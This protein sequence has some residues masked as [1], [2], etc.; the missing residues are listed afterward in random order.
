MGTGNKKRMKGKER[1]EE[2]EE[3]IKMVARESEGE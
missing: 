3:W 1:E 2:G